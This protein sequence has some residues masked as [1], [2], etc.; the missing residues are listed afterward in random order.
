MKRQKTDAQDEKG[1]KK[2]LAVTNFLR[3][4]KDS[5]R[6]S[7]VLWEKGTDVLNSFKNMPIMPLTKNCAE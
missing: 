4:F 5:K 2:S 3:K 1:T 6:P 7:P